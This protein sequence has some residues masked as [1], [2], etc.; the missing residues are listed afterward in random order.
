[1][2][3]AT[4]ADHRLAVYGSLAPGG[5]NHGQVSA[6]EGRWFDGQVRG[7]L[8]AIGWGVD[9]GYPGIV[10]DDDADSV[11]VQVFESSDLPAHWRR[12][13]DFEGSGYQRVLVT[14]ETAA[15]NLPAW[16]YAIARE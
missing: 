4:T 11:P 16:I 7:H 2:K 14:V 9:I 3:E 12:L 8:H 15:G 5:P 13:D 6:L 10:L 1:M